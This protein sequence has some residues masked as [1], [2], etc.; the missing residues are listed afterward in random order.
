M[1]ANFDTNVSFCR[2]C[3]MLLPPLPSHGNV[4]CLY[5][6]VEVP[7]K[8]FQIAEMSYDIIFNKRENIEKKRK[9]DEEETEGPTVERKCPKCG[10]DTMSYAALQLRSADEGQTVFYTC[11]KCKYKE[12]ENS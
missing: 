8:D 5:C 9:H 6:R 4:F 1:E 3:G 2:E 10:H 12:A 11:L 7:I